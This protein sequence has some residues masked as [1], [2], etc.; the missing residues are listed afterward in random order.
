M[1]GLLQSP[2]EVFGGSGFIGEYYTDRYDSIVAPRKSVHPISPNILYFR[3]T[4]D[5]YNI[6]TDP[7]LDV[8]TNVVLLLETLVNLYKTYGKDAIVNYISTWFVYGDV[9]LPARENADLRTKGGLY[10]LSKAY[11]ER[12][13]QA[14]CNHTGMGYRIMRLANVLGV[15][16]TNKSLKKNATGYLLSEINKG[17]SVVIYDETSIRDFIDVRDCVDA[18]HLVATKGK[19]NEI[20]NIG[21]GVS[22]GVQSLIKDYARSMGKLDLIQYKYVPK[23]HKEVQS[24]NFMM[25]VGKLRALGFTNKYTITDTLDWIKNE[26]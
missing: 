10:S 9:D 16:D 20:Y 22:Y 15:G 14:Y 3:S 11:A 8:K 24:R 1:S 12:V 25:D 23:F 2:L 21:S 26:K 5:N 4:T 17:N 6:D 18:I 13:V 19:V 7:T